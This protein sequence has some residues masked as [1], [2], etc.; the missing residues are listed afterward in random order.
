MPL[1]LQRYWLAGKGAAKIRWG[2]PHDFNRC[3]R[4]LRKYFPKNP[5]G[6]C[7]ILHQKALGAA[8]GKGHG[9]SLLAAMGEGQA[10]V[11]AQ[12]L[13]NRQ[14]LLG[15]F[16]WAGPLAPIGR[17]TE[18]PNRK[19]IFEM[20]AL[21]HRVLPLPL[22]WR[23][24]SSSKGHD[25]GVTVGRILGIGYGPNEAGME[26]A[27][28]WGD[29]LSEDIIPAAKKAR[30]LVDQGVVGTSV[31]PGGRYVVTIDPMTGVEHASEFT[32]GGATMVSIAAFSGMHLFNMNEEGD[33]PDHDM[34]MVMDLEDDEDC[35]C[36]GH[37]P[38]TITAAVNPNGWKG[39]PL[40]QR[41]SVFDNDDAVKRITA[42]A[43][44]GQDTEKMRQAFMYYNPQGNPSDPTSYR[45]PVGDIINGNL[46]LIFHAIY[47]AAAL[48]S[49]AHGGLPN[50]PEQDK[51]QLRQV[52]SE[53]YEV[54]A[55]EFGDQT[56]R[57]PWDRSVQPGVQMS[58]TYATD[59]TNEKTE[60]YGDVEYADPGYRNGTKRYPIDTP[61]H[62]RAAWSYINQAKNAAFYDARQLA[63]IRAKIKA[64][65]KRHGIEISE[66]SMTASISDTG[67]P[68]TPPRSW[69][70]NPNLQGKT[71]M[72]VTSDGRV[73]GH[74]AAWGECHRDMAMRECVLAPKS[75][76][77]YAPFHLG[78]V[79]TEE[80]ETIRV[81]KIVMDTNHADVR[82]GYTAAAGHYDHTGTEVAVVRA[83]EDAY[84]IWVA[85]SLVPEADARMAAKLRRS[86]L[87]GDWRRQNGN[88]ELTA[89]LAVNAPAFPVYSMEADGQWSL[90]AAGSV[91]PSY[92]EEETVPEELTSIDPEALVAAVT[93]AVD[94]LEDEWLGQRFDDLLE[95]EE[96]YDQREQGARFAALVA[97]SQDPWTKPV[98]QPTPP[99]VAPVPGGGP[100][101]G[102]GGVGPGAAPLDAAAVN[103]AEAEMIAMNADAQYTVTRDPAE[104]EDADQ[105]DEADAATQ[106]PTPQVPEAQ[107]PVQQP[108][109]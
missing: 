17:L 34:D 45:L 77:Q 72:T 67:F 86:P 30:Y 97:A 90:V 57:A 2:L 5:E 39:I 22:D 82:L 50:I 88:L 60:P 29:Y 19:R 64:A 65:A 28:G 91:Y 80:G 75:R 109:Q 46:T 26:F 21:R 10:L 108:V 1:P 84:G 85:G 79:V 68:L 41:Q 101:G 6:L 66:D 104:I 27:W 55:D 58:A 61:E 73:F 52:I 44:G 71:P 51:G 32:I 103:P 106:Q 15:E 7:N 42:W 38:T 36:D 9:H 8:P 100:G 87:S 25:G 102:P 63:S 47:A 12:A 48:L 96:I 54:M 11:A 76:Q 4:N 43:N 31:D 24:H 59:S 83:G 95:D 107:P 56:I 23:E 93:E 49:G 35:G 74:L 70:D 81:G 18:E 14:P 69:F 89:A 92:M 37:A 98:P 94:D 20:E 99:A 3:V 13:M 33:W 53:I 40:A 105:F 62:V 78:T 16:L